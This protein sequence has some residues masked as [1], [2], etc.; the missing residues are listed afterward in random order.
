MTTDSEARARLE[1]SMAAE[2]LSAGQI[3]QLRRLAEFTPT[4]IGRQ[5]MAI[6]AYPEVDGSNEA[7]FMPQMIGQRL[8]LTLDW[9]EEF[10][11]GRVEYR[12]FTDNERRRLVFAHQKLGLPMV[13]ATHLVMNKKMTTGEMEETYGQ[14]GGGKRAVI[15]ALGTLSMQGKSM[16]AI[17]MKKRGEVVVDLD[18]FSGASMEDYIEALGE[19]WREMTTEEMVAK[20]KEVAGRGGLANSQRPWTLIEALDKLAAVYKDG[21]RPELVVCD[22]PGYRIPVEGEEARLFNGFDFLRDRGMTGIRLERF[23][24]GKLLSEEKISWRVIDDYLKLW[25]GGW[26][27]ACLEIAEM[28]ETLFGDVVWDNDNAL[29]IDHMAYVGLLRQN[30]MVMEEGE[31]VVD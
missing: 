16:L 17:E 20:I 25:E 26:R 5:V 14:A 8:L 29:A 9:W 2:P 18:K 10:G 24:G 6:V 4:V 31:M 15:V 11:M 21:N 30:L 12:D 27:Q 13:V 1:A 19:G 3:E 7:V 22:M 23:E 28:E